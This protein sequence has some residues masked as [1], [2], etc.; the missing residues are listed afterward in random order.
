VLFVHDEIVVEADADKADAAADW[1]KQ[2]MIDGMKDV[3]APVP[4]EV[5]AKANTTW[6]G[7]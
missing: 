6:G 2:A 1:L 7:D 5:E 4:C 3:L